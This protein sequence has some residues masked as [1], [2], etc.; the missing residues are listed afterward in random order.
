M[1]L[2]YLYLL[3]GDVAA[4]LYH[5]HTV[6]KGAGNGVQV[7]RRGDEQHFRE[8]VVHIEI[9]VVE[10]VVLLRVE[11]LKQGRGGVAV[12]GVLRHLVYLVENEHGVRRTGTLNA[13]DDAA[14]HGADVGAAVTADLRLVVKTAQRHAHVFALHG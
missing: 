2:R 1:A 11:H 10:S 12:D 6:E 14:G 5:L 9:V 13:L 3:L 7:V 4:H 8:V